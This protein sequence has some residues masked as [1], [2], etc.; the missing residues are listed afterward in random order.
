MCSIKSWE[1]EN[2]F[3]RNEMMQSSF[4][5]YSVY[6]FPDIYNYSKISLSTAE[7]LCILCFLKCWLYIAQNVSPAQTKKLYYW[8]DVVGGYNVGW[9]CVLGFKSLLYKIHCLDHWAAFL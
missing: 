7:A 5:T 4:Y 6:V 2:D 9:F 8:L 1:V 3:C